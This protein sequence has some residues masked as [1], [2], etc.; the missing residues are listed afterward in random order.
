[1]ESTCRLRGG[2]RHSPSALVQGTDVASSSGLKICSSFP[3]VGSRGLLG[4]PQTLPKAAERPG[5]VRGA[6][7]QALLPSRLPLGRAPFHMATLYPLSGE[8]LCLVMSWTQS[9]GKSGAEPELGQALQNPEPLPSP[10]PNTGRHKPA[11][12]GL[13]L[14]STG[15]CFCQ[16]PHFT[17]GPQAG[18]KGRK[19]KP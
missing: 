10:W 2:A 15:A 6:G 1:M 14:L 5:W 11:A 7:R 12:P 8:R 16:P 3:A 4:E 13:G 19:E 9:R 18:K 17:Q